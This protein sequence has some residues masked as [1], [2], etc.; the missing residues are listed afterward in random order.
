VIAFDRETGELVGSASDVQALLDGDQYVEDE[1][2]AAAVA[3]AQAP[4]FR[5]WTEGFEPAASVLGDGAL[6]VLV[7]ERAGDQRALL[8]TQTAQLPVAL[9]AWLGLGPRPAPGHPPIRLAPGAMAVVIGRTQAHGHDLEPAV[10]NDLQERLDAGVRHWTLRFAR[11][12]WRR[13][14]EVLEGERGIW[15][16]RPVDGDL[17]ELAPTSTTAVVRELIALLLTAAAR[18]ESEPIRGPM[19]A[20][21]PA[22]PS[23]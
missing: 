16:I 8:P 6:C 5:V 18:T 22:T 15:R 21:R 9:V 2:V 1:A 17:V 12:G 14:L 10:A 23:D 20:D 11:G 13:N 19:N 3:A 4:T 7:T